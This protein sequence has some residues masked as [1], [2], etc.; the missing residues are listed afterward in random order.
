MF[1]A[2]SLCAATALV[3]ASSALSTARQQYSDAMTAIDRGRWTEYEELRPGLE[4][5][6]L[7]IYLDYYRLTGPGS[8]VRPADAQRFLRASEDTPLPNRFL[9]VYLR[10]AGKERRW[11]DFLALMPKEPNSVDLKCYYFRAR[12]AAGDRAT[13]WKGA[14]EL[15][16]Y[17]RSRPDE[18]D[19]LFEAWMRSG[20]LTDGIVWARMLKAFEARQRSL[21]QY[22]ARKGSDE[23]RPWADKLIAVYR[24]PDRISVHHLPPGN[25]YSADIISHGL[26]YLARFNPELALERWPDY[27]QSHAFSAEQVRMVEREIALRNL[28]AENEASSDWLRGALERLADDKLVEIRLRWALAE[29]DWEGLAAHLPLLSEEKRGD[30]A[31]RYWGAILDERRGRG[32]PAREALALLAQERGYYSFLAADRLRQPYSFRHAPLQLEEA[33]DEALRRIPAMARIEE[34]QFHDKET[35]AHSEWYKILQD[36][37]DQSERRQLAS[38]AYQQGWYRF[39]IDAAN[40]AKASDLLDLRFPL[41]YEDTFSRYASLQQVPS[42]ELM[43]IARRESAFFPRARSPV[44]ARGLMQIMRA[45]GKQVASS[46][47]QRHSTS[48]LYQVD[49]NVLLGSA[50]YRQLLDRS[51]GNR[52]FALTAYNAGP[53]RVDRWRKASAGALPV[54]VWI[55]TIPFRET[56]NYVQAVLTYNVVFQYLLGQE[57][58]LL[59]PAERTLRY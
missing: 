12:L 14:A 44:G 16:D 54:E 10:R 27:R 18:C 55:E 17:G 59:T 25:P 20:E 7:A 15:W 58:S 35:L 2:G 56:R 43:A 8:P 21:M 3:Q 32:E 50:Y 1:L 34:L 47:G 28:F 23:L 37:E 39:A 38:L 42:T 51:D 30:S 31:W 36:R 29:Q 45:T 26:T 46:I 9:T 24:Q 40:K 57:H 13:A 6:P 49:H 53:H 52:V 41:A 48:A 22:V 33:A 5:Y 11:D 19:P 4:D